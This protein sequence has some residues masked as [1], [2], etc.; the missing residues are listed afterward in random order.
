MSEQDQRPV[1]L[2]RVTLSELVPDSV[3]S[4]VVGIIIA[5]QDVRSYS[6]TTPNG[7]VDG[8]VWNFT[9]R[10]S[11]SDYINVTCWSEHHI[12]KDMAEKY[13][14]GDVGKGKH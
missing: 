8:A 1:G 3:N 7:V 13:L 4:L 12:L 5:K 11:P 2:Q 10:D 14:V 9:F 6:K